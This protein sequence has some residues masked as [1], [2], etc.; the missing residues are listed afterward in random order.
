MQEKH[1]PCGEAVTGGHIESDNIL[2]S[3]VD[4]RG[5]DPILSHD[6][7][8]SY[9]SEDQPV[10]IEIAQALERE[11]YR[12][13]YAHRDITAGELRT[14]SLTQAIQ[15][16]R[17]FLLIS[18][19]HSA[20]SQAVKDEVSAAYK[21]RKPILPVHSG[22]SQDQLQKSSTFELEYL[23][24]GSRTALTLP[25]GGVESLVPRLLAT[26]AAMGISPTED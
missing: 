6:V 14:L 1:A 21:K 12:T 20:N 4:Q 19:P 17:V 11:G 23:L 13:W 18:S 8:I 25:A 9:S 26:L 22:M 5:A 10:A 7:F 15:Q 16:T 2:V 24:T 3:L